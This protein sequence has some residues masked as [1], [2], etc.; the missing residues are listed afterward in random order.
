M[1]RGDGRKKTQP[2]L[3]TAKRNPFYRILPISIPLFFLSFLL[4]FCP[5]SKARNE[6]KGTTEELKLNLFLYYEAY[7]AKQKKNRRSGKFANWCCVVFDYL[8]TF[9][10]CSGPLCSEFPR[11]NNLRST[12][13]APRKVV[14]GVSSGLYLS[15]HKHPIRFSCRDLAYC[16]YP[17]VS[18]S[19]TTQAFWPQSTPFP[20]LLNW[21]HCWKHW[22]FVF[23]FSFG[24]VYNKFHFPFHLIF[25]PHFLLGRWRGSM[26]AKAEEARGD[27]WSEEQKLARHFVYENSIC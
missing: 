5:C 10:A 17:R 27:G 26:V 9:F 4:L 7:E 8:F 24:C 14:W 3:N 1:I 25:F 23:H 6:Q 22:H 13:N 12:C 11:H 15:S 21:K 2:I 18:F 19:T 20:L 16:I